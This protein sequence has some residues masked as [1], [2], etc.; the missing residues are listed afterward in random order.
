MEACCNRRS[1][2]IF[3]MVL[4]KHVCCLSQEAFAKNTICTLLNSM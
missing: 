4:I 3:N 2:V 1:D